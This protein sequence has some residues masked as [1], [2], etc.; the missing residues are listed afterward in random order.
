[1][2]LL[3]SPRGHHQ[4]EKH[5]SRATGSLTRA[6]SGHFRIDYAA[7]HPRKRGPLPAR[8]VRDGGQTRS[9]GGFLLTSAQV[10]QAEFQAAQCDVA[11]VPQADCQAIAK[12]PGGVKSS[13]LKVARIGSAAPTAATPRADHRRRPQRLARLASPEREAFDG[14][15]CGNHVCALPARLWTDLS[16][17]ASARHQSRTRPALAVQSEFLRRHAYEWVHLCLAHTIARTGKAARHP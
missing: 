12:K 14:Q 11:A 5:Y 13:F 8:N 4:T 9:S 16:T 3:K 15:Y 10:P 17:M 2:A 7:L 6:R 1:M